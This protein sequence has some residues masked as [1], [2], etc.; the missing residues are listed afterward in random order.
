MG[1]VLHPC[2]DDLVC[3]S[4]NEKIPYFNAPMY[5]ENKE[6]IG[7]VDEIF[8]HLTEPVSFAELLSSFLLRV[9]NWVLFSHKP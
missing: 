2:Q 7:K 4:T 8:G 5:L 6:Q 9:D 1:T 3:R